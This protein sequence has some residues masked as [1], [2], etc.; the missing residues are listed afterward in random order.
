V[1]SAPKHPYS[2][3]LKD[4]VLSPDVAAQGQLSAPSLPLDEDTSVKAL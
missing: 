1:L 4:S 3:L 2:I